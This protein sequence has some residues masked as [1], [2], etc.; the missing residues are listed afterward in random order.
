MTAPSTTYTPL[1]M[2]SSTLAVGG[3]FPAELHRGS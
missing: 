2:P 1:L 3:F